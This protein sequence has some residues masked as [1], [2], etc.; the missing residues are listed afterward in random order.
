M[1]YYVRQLSAEVYFGADMGGEVLGFCCLGVF[2]SFVI[3]HASLPLC[4]LDM[5]LVGTSSTLFCSCAAL[6]P[7]SNSVICVGINSV[8]SSE[9]PTSGTIVEVVQIWSL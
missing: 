6:Q 3:L 2:L 5:R 7:A 9:M 1:W 4:C 8:S